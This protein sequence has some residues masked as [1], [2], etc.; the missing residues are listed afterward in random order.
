MMMMT[1][2]GALVSI[3]GR[4]LFMGSTFPIVEH[5]VWTVLFQ[6]PFRRYN[7]SMP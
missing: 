1:D 4:H 5:S 2:L 7:P 3:A 6:P